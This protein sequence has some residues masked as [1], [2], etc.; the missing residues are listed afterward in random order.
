MT[1]E[2]DRNLRERGQTAT[3]EPKTSDVPGIDLDGL[4][5]VAREATQERWKAVVDQRRINR[6]R[7]DSQDDQAWI[8]D[9]VQAT[10]G[11]FPEC[12]ARAAHIAAF[13]PPTVLALIALAR[14]AQPPQARE[15]EDGAVERLKA[16]A[17]GPQADSQHA[18][19]L[20]TILAK[21][22]EQAAEI[23]GF[24]AR[25]FTELARA[26]IDTARARAQA[27][28]A[29]L[30]E[31]L[32]GRDR[33]LFDAQTAISKP[34]NMQ[35]IRLAVGEGKLSPFVVLDGA[36]AELRRRAAELRAPMQKGGE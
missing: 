36:N 13:D 30:A 4:E 8:A 10:R 16:W 25:H 17:C 22:E 9:I 2:H 14:S 3:A 7:V 5:K 33:V 27:A 21:V 15:A 23:E 35:D 31:A 28:E 32:E 6:W 26:A 18:R 11:Y 29:R 19:D 20:T 1:A 24:R 12:A 34:I